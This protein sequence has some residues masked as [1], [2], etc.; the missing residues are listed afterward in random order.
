MLISKDFV[1]VLLYFFIHK[2]SSRLVRGR[3][4]EPTTKMVIGICNDPDDNGVVTLF[5]A[6]F[7]VKAPKELADPR[8]TE[9]ERPD[10]ERF[11]ANHSLVVAE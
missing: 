3:K 2:A 7:G 10:A 5:T 11:W 4:A 8:M 1:D 6:F 9:A